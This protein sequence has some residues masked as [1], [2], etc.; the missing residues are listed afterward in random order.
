MSI[1]NTIKKIWYSLYP[2]GR[3]ILLDYPS[4]PKRIYEEN[5]KPHVSLYQLI[6]KNKATYKQFLA[7]T[8]KYT[9]AFANIKEDRSVSD[10]TAPGWN[11]G[12]FP[13][14]DMIMLYSLLAQLKPLQYI[15]IGSGT[16]TK[17]AHQSKKDNALAVEIVSIDPSPRKQITAVTDKIIQQKIQDTDLSLFDS[18]KENDIVFLEILPRLKKGVIVQ[19]HDVYLP[20][21]YPD[22]MCQ[23]FYSEQ[24]LLAAL[25]LA[26]P[27]KYEII[28]PNYFIYTEKDLLNM[29]D[30]VWQLPSLQQV[31]QHGG[32]F[33]FRIK[34]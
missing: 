22:F 24:Y 11:N 7:D 15:E 34:E 3:V 27:D 19:I 23:R 33:W 5:G 14:L 21:D 32:S 12:H 10:E 17:V 1:K 20:Y 29:L 9:S 31:E 4:S 13:G 25:L 16:S 26:N 6:N 30:Q 2:S 18:L 8:L 28:C